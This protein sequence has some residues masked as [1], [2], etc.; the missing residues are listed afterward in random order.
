MLQRCRC[1]MST[2]NLLSS[3]LCALPCQ[4]AFVVLQSAQLY[5]P[6]QPGVP[7]AF[8]LAGL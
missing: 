5:A 2:V 1:V 4:T 6:Q 7:L 8:A 3:W